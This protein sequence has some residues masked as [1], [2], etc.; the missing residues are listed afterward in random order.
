MRNLIASVSFVLIVVAGTCCVSCG[1][2]VDPFRK[3]DCPA[4]KTTTYSLSENEKG[5]VTYSGYDTLKFIQWPSNAIYTFNGKG[6]VIGYKDVQVTSMIT[7]CPDNIAKCEYR[8]FVFESQILNN[9]LFVSIYEE[10]LLDASQAKFVFQEFSAECSIGSLF[11]QPTY[12]T[13]TVRG[14][15]YKDVHRITPNG[16]ITDTS[17]YLLYTVKEGV[18]KIKISQN[19]YWEK[20]Q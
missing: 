20:I 19:E 9:E 15:P 17:T 10:G 8:N 1:S 12:S 5:I 16:S 6:K 2:E 3:N 13:I 7:Y 18:I 11:A 4:S 14:I